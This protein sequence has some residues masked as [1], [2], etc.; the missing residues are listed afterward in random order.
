MLWGVS[1]EKGRLFSLLFFYS[2]GTNM[3]NRRRVPERACSL[4]VHPLPLVH[5]VPA[6][7]FSIA[8]E[9]SINLYTGC[10]ILML[11]EFV[12]ITLAFSTNLLVALE[13]SRRYALLTQEINVHYWPNKKIL[14][15]NFSNNSFST[16]IAIHKLK[17][18][19]SQ[20]I[21]TWERILKLALVLRSVQSNLP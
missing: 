3:A 14:L 7:H 11:T 17:P 9:R 4:G 2:K 6:W 12:N 8:R 15:I 18:V 1:R 13:Y 19:I 5:L 20:G 16:H 10:F 21:S